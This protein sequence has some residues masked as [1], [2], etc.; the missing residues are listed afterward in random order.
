[1]V[2]R[3]VVA[4]SLQTY[5]DIPQLAYVNQ[6]L[7]R[8]LCRQARQSGNIPPH[9][10]PSWHLTREKC[11]EQRDRDGP[12]FRNKPTLLQGLWLRDYRQVLQMPAALSSRDPFTC[13]TPSPRLTV[14]IKPKAGYTAVSPLV[15]PL[16][17]VKY[18]TCR[19]HLLHRGTSSPLY[20]PLDL[21]SRSAPRIRQ[22]LHSLVE[23]PR[24][25]FRVW[26]GSQWC[27]EQ[28]SEALPAWMEGSTIE[29]FTHILSQ[30]L[31]NEDAFLRQI[32]CLQKLDVVDSD[33]AVRVY[34]RL[35]QHWL[36]GSSTR[37]SQLL[38]HC[39]NNKNRQPA[40]ETPMIAPSQRHPRLT[41]CPTTLLADLSETSL[42]LVEYLDL[43]VAL[44]RCLPDDV[45]RIDGF[46]QKAIALVNEMNQDDCLVLLRLWLLSLA[47][48]DL[49]FFVGMQAYVI[50]DGPKLMDTLPA[51]S[52][53]FHS[54]QTTENPGI[55]VYRLGEKVFHIIYEIKAI[56]C[57]QKPAR[58]LGSRGQKEEK[59]FSILATS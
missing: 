12:R 1:L 14:E 23:A 7:A 35:V 13:T 55:A 58:K 56:D 21:F 29:Q 19:Y 42:A 44:E 26:L 51:E 9:R 20:S 22:S 10:R 32:L 52:L 54:N 8:A 43:V 40:D 4:P 39:P 33:G 34:N 2:R 16:R 41:G 11:D 38:D 27:T 36:N 53:L 3:Y 15:D 24:N 46:H 18:R 31:L 28:L 45:K 57:D 37:A 47:M 17:R 25:N 49:S 50:P 48:C 30:I 6:A 5:L 59:L